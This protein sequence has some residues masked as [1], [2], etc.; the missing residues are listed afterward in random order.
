MIWYEGI[1]EAI[2][3]SK[4]LTHAVAG[5]IKWDEVTVNFLIRVAA[6]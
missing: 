3:E 2:G 6:G 5:V 4:Q 1:R